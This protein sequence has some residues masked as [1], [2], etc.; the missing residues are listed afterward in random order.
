MRR[1][2]LRW[3]VWA[4]WAV[5]VVGLYAIV[6]FFVVPKIARWQIEKQS[7]ALLHRNAT[8]TAV[9]FNPFTLA[10]VV[11][12]LDLKDRDGADLFHLDR[13]SVNFQIVGV[14]RRAFRFREIVLERPQVVARIAADGHLSIADIF[15]S[16]DT[17]KP[18][19]PKSSP[20]RILID[21]FALSGGAAKFVD[22]SKTLCSSKRSP[23]ST[24]SSTS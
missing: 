18:D 7:R 20:V 23:L 22:E 6:G 16:Q 9:R 8:V 15:D 1:L 11:E 19:A 5:A 24:S 2:A 21:R 13:L 4:A 17:E 12:G 14:F 3:R 10:A